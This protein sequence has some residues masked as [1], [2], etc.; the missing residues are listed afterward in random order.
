MHCKDIHEELIEAS[1]TGAIENAAVRE[2]LASCASCAKEWQAMRRTMAALDSWQAPEPSPYFDTR[3]FAR[4]EEEKRRPAS[5]GERLTA[6][7][8]VRWQAAA[9]MALA[10]ALAVGASIY[11]PLHNAGTQK[12]TVAKSSA[13]DDLKALEKNKDLLSAM[14]DLDQAG[15]Q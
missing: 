15:E 13:V 4:L 10:A 2:H 6:M 14:D 12:P 7:L 1:F 5:L 11:I 9:G 8:H 3:L